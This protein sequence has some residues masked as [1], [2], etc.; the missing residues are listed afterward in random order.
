MMSKLKA[1][2][3]NSDKFNISKVLQFDDNEM[4]FHLPEKG[5]FKIPKSM[6]IKQEK[7]VRQNKNE[8]EPQKNE[9]IEKKNEIIK[10]KKQIKKK[11]RPEN[12]RED[13]E[14][15]NNNIDYVY[16]Y[17][18][19][20]ENE[21][22]IDDV[23]DSVKKVIVTEKK[24]IHFRFNFPILNMEM[25]KEIQKIYTDFSFENEAVNNKKKAN[26]QRHIEKE[27]Q[28]EIGI[29]GKD[30]DV[31]NFDEKNE[32]KTIINHMKHSKK[33]QFNYKKEKNLI[34]L[35]DIQEFLDNKNEKENE[36]QLLQTLI[37][38]SIPITTRIQVI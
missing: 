31:A 25:P 21:N 19:K 5:N 3:F 36:I 30:F 7:K 4:I 16:D 6:F 38:L 15:D 37:D 17:D 12:K 14:N 20:I 33:T 8:L 13:L 11:I 10:P 26:N 2:G 32:I 18:N 23:F 35:Q 1:L 29:T 22:G 24:E 9:I 28:S 34:F 27:I